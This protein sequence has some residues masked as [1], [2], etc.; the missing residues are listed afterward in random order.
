MILIFIFQ[1]LDFFTFFEN[2]Y[3]IR[4]VIVSFAGFIIQFGYCSVYFRMTCF[5]KF[6]VVGSKCIGYG[7][8]DPESI[9]SIAGFSL[10]AMISARESNSECTGIF[11]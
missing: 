11:L 4:C 10:G 8:F 5:M 2:S 9:W 3:F 7:W 1:L 6:H